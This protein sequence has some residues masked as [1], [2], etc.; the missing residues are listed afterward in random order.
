MNAFSRYVISFIPMIYA[1]FIVLSSIG[2]KI[3]LA[4]AFVAFVYTCL[5]VLGSFVVMAI[6]L[7]IMNFVK[8]KLIK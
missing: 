1:G 4:D 7:G 2:G 3:V 5:C 6:M 8:N